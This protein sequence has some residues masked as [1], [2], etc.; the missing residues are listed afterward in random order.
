MKQRHSYSH[1]LFHL[2]LR[3]KNREHLIVSL[4]DEKRLPG[5]FKKKAHD[6]DTYVEEFGSWYDHV[7]LLLSTKP[8]IALS[9]VYGQLKGFAAYSWQQ[10]QPTR[11]FKWKD[12]V[13]VVTVTPDDCATL[14]EYIRNQRRH[15]AEKNLMPS[16]EPEP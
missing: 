9:D 6:L 1:L 4:E 2:V 12:G 8:A 11:P 13:W 5:Y 16:F 15:H 14:R 10:D 7:H 3:I